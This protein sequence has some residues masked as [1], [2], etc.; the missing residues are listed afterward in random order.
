MLNDV[1]GF[2]S[3]QDRGAET[4]EPASKMAGIIAGLGQGG[5]IAR[6]DSS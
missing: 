5:S 2:G 1:W 4:T 6:D 3:R